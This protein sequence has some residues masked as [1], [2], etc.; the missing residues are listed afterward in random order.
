[1][2]IKMNKKTKKVLSVVFGLAVILGL[3]A[4]VTNLVKNKEDDGFKEIHPTFVYGG[5]DGSG[6]YVETKES[7]YTKD[8]IVADKL[9]VTLDFDSNVQ[10]QLFFYDELDQFIECSEKMD[11]NLAISKVDPSHLS[12]VPYSFRLVLYPV[13]DDTTEDK[14]IGLLEKLK[15]TSQ[16]KIEVDIFDE[17]QLTIYDADE[18]NSITI[19]YFEG[20][21]WYD[22]VVSDVSSKYN[23]SIDE[24]FIFVNV[25]GKTYRID[26]AYC[27]YKILL[28]TQYLLTPAS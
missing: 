6:K 18:E 2:K 12:T 3:A 9:K 4:L 10:Y 14:E 28:S 26:N 15:Y 25:N 5:L 24:D 17:L 22:W 20:M 8:A 1:M 19:I 13:L 27:D 23:A 11:T 7:L 16:I 21:D